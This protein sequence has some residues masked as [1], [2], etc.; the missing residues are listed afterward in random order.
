MAVIVHD[1]SLHELGVL[2]LCRCFK[3]SRVTMSFHNKQFGGLTNPSMHG[4]SRMA[5]QHPRKP[6]TIMRA[7]ATMR[8]YTP[9]QDRHSITLDEGQCGGV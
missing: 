6:T 1:F 3:L 4:D 2:F 9:V 8:R 7:P 5:P